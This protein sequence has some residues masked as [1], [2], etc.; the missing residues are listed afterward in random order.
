[1]IAS[2]R[3]RF[4]LFP[5]LA[6]PAG[7]RA[8]AAVLLLLS[9]TGCATGSDD[10]SAQA[11]PPIGV[12][13]RM[14]VGKPQ[15]ASPPLSLQKR[16]PFRAGRTD[17]LPAELANA[18]FSFRA[19]NMPLPD[20][21]ALFAQAYRLNVVPDPDVLGNI[22]VSFENLPLKKAMEVLLSA[23]RYYWL[24]EDGVIWVRRLVTKIF[25]VDYLR[26][27]RTAS[28]TF[29]GSAGGGTTGGTTTTGTTGATGTTGG[30]GGGGGSVNLSQ[31]NP[32]NFWTELDTQLKSLISAQGKLVINTLAGTIQVTDLYQNVNQIESFLAS[33][34]QGIHRQ[35]DIEGTIYEVELQKD[36]SAGI[37]WSLLKAFTD[38][39]ITAATMIANPVGGFALKA[40]TLG[41]THRSQSA[42]A[43]LNFLKQHGNVKIVSEP[44][45]RALNNQSAM[46][47]VGTDRT[48]FTQASTLT[49]TPIAGTTATTG[50]TSFTETP[51]VVT[52]GLVLWITPQ[53]SADGWIMLDISPILTRLVG[54][55]ESK[56][57]STA[58]ILEIK[59]ASALIRGRDGETLVLGGLIQETGSDSE[60]KIPY[61][62]DLP[63][64]GVAFR[65]SY[66]ASLRKE[67]VI[68]L[69]LRIV[70]TP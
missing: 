35:V 68:F 58:P 51:V 62:G 60:R 32:V 33:L 46:L 53:I 67:I 1:M 20:A 9:L 37:D 69:T 6:S 23:H 63:T 45:I 48:F 5:M 11:A 28:G 65:G 12:R 10:K 34:T 15:D 14:P 55:T 66:Q 38:T 22:T 41:I 57:G 2:V 17:G 27:S 25:T 30:A 52:D 19:E 54:S 29:S 21:L 26:L 59:Q 4:H 70:D 24:W 18:R 8:A 47:K 36:S 49:T 13:E 39:T 16:M 3:P 50:T 44:R 7:L 64:A 56:Q 40:A 42:T 61:L 43:V 31:Q